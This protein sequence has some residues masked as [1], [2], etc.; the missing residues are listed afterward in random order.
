M[1]AQ[2]QTRFESCIRLLGHC[3]AVAMMVASTGALAGAVPQS[4]PAEHGSPAWFV[5]QPD[6]NRPAFRL[7]PAQPI[8]ECAADAERLKAGG[9]DERNTLM[10]NWKQISATCQAALSKQLVRP[11]AIDLSD[12]PTCVR[13]VICGENNGQGISW[14]TNPQATNEVPRQRIEWKSNPEN[15]GYAIS[16]PYKLPPGA[17]GAVSVGVD[18]K[19]NLWVLQRAPVGVPALSKFSPDGKLL[20]QVGDDVIGHLNKAHGMNVDAQDNAWIADSSGSV[21]M[22]ISPQ[23]KLLQTIGV[24]GKRGDWDETKGQR[25]L[26]QPVSIAFGPEGDIYIGEGHGNESPNDYQSGDPWNTSGAARVIRLDK[27]GNFKS[28]IYGNMTGPGKFSYVHD[29][30]IDPKNG[31][32]WIGDREEYRLVVYNSEGK[33]LRT[34]QTRN[35]TCNIA[36]DKNGDLWIGTGGDGQFLKMTRDGKVL[37]AIGNGPGGGIG[38]TGETGYIRWDSKGNL[39]TG[40]TTQPRVTVFTPP[41]N[42]R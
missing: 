27:N 13:S 19:D 41:R 1:K 33:F 26:W 4:G 2:S 20:F 30:A 32:L 10:A 37:E 6:G 29:L 14:R 3:G 15:M 17:N 25:L 28:Q 34:I 39:I 35:L 12:V 38:Q 11:G 36:F 18:S 7:P 40:S 23:G 22:K 9:P 31:D 5:Y 42:Q 21:I 16:Y 24:H 8:A